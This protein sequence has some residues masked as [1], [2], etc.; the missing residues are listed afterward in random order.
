MLWVLLLG[1]LVLVPGMLV[2]KLPWVARGL[3][4]VRGQSN[5]VNFALVLNVKDSQ[6]SC[7]VMGGVCRWL[8]IE[9]RL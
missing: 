4:L 3:R 1:C 7:L 2:C 9:F 8:N 5:L 6:V